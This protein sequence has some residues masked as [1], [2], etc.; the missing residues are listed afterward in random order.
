MLGSAQMGYQLEEKTSDTINITIPSGE[1]QIW[2]LILELPFDSTRKRMS[3]IVKL[4][5][6]KD[7]Q[8]YLFTKGAD[9]AMIPQIHLTDDV[10]TQVKNTLEKFA[11]EGLRTLVVGKKTLRESE[12]KDIQDKYMK[13]SLSSDKDKER[14]ISNLFEEIESGF[15]Y[16]GC[17]AIE[18]KL[19]DVYI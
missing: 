2:D 11:Q 18:D 19:Q 8:L 14:Q 13:I 16:I 10:L 7:N 1:Y 5:D 9:T 15:S 6:S 4:K 12:V 3:V 17:T